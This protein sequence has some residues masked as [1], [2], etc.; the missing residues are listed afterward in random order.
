MIS[1]K[2]TPITALNPI[3]EVVIIKCSQILVSRF[4]YNNE[5][6]ISL[7]HGLTFS[8]KQVIKLKVIANLPTIISISLVLANGGL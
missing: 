8:G 4:I 2:R 5:D 7:L 1:G 6:Y 3:I